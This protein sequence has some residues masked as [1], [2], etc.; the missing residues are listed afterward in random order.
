[1]SVSHRSGLH[2]VTHTHTGVCEGPHN[3]AE[4]DQKTVFVAALVE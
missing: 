3:H 4:N 1:M 2:S